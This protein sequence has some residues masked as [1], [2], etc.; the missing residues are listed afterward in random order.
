MSSETNQVVKIKPSYVPF[1]WKGLVVVIL[2]VAL[3][4]GTLAFPMLL[5]SLPGFVFGSL[6]ILASLAIVGLG[7]LMVLVGA[8]RRSMYTYQVTDSHVIIQK[9]LLRRSVRRIPFASISD[10]EISQS[11]VGRLAKYGNLV[12]ITKS[13]YGL[14]RGMESTENVVAEMTN[15]PNPDKIANLIM[16]RVS[17]VAKAINQ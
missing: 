6:V 1:V 9:Q 2:G 15:V 10:V 11:F 13:G 17:L 16:S 14:V 5:A 3:L 12:P 8:V 4:V 7:L